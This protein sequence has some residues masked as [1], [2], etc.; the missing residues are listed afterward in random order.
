MHSSACIGVCLMESHLI[1][2]RVIGIK[3][4]GSCGYFGVY[5]CRRVRLAGSIGQWDMQG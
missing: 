1:H 4:D 5:M 2:P 3:G